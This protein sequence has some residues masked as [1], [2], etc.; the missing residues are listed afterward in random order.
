MP[1]GPREVLHNA[2][3]AWTQGSIQTFGLLPPPI[4]LDPLWI[5]VPG[6]VLVLFA[7]IMPSTPDSPPMP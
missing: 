5:F 4:A 1:V 2:H 3:L 6:F 7:S